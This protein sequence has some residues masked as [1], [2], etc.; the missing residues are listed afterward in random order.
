MTKDT[1]P[2]TGED[3]LPPFECNLVTEKDWPLPLYFGDTPTARISNWLVGS[4]HTA[5]STS[6][7]A[8]FTKQSRQTTAKAIKTMIRFKILKVL[9][10]GKTTEY[11]WDGM[12]PAAQGLKAFLRT[13]IDTIVEEQIEYGKTHKPMPIYE[14]TEIEL[15]LML[16]G[17]HKNIPDNHQF[18]LIDPER[19]CNCGHTEQAHDSYHKICGVPDC[20]C[21]DYIKT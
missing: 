9:K 1:A 14:G 4:P 16:R 15:R 6:E 18:V 17:E 2:A 20:T 19:I 10:K 13:L 7:I 11:Q 5:Y 21:K 3:E 8:K 12:S